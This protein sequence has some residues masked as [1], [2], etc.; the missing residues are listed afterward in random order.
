MESF[1]DTINRWCRL[2]QP[3]EGGAGGESWDLDEHGDS[4]QTSLL[5]LQE[6]QKRGI[7][8]YLICSDRLGSSP[9]FSMTH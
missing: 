2:T 6:L 3:P 4:E 9:D 5:Q 7:L 8:D 1:E